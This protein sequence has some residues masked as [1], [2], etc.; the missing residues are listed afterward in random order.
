MTKKDLEKLAVG[1]IYYKQSPY[2]CK[3]CYKVEVVE[4]LNDKE[5]M[6]KGLTKSKKGKKEA[7]PFKTSIASLHTSPSKAT[8]GFKKGR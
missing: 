3:S 5:A 7:K 8:G 1:N 6:V 2:D 4:I